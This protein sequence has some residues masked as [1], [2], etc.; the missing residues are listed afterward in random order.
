MNILLDED[1]TTICTFLSPPQQKNLK[2]PNQ[3]RNK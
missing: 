1:K 2:N 3:I